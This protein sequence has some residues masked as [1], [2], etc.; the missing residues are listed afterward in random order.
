MKKRKTKTT[1]SGNF[2]INQNK[3]LNT[4]KNQQIK[5]KFN[6]DE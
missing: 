6:P 3:L 2:H 5:C 1:A 4:L